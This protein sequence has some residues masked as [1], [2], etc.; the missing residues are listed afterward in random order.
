MTNHNINKEELNR[1]RGRLVYSAMRILNVL[2]ECVSKLRTGFVDSNDYYE[3]EKTMK[4]L[5]SELLNINVNLSDLE[6]GKKE[7]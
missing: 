3:T 6:N 2:E 5:E 4:R 7:S 1:E